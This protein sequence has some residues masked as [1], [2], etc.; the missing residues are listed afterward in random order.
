MFKKL[1]IKTKIISSTILSLISLSVILGGISVISSKDAL[2]QKSYSVLT[3]VRDS[4]VKQIN[5]FF[6]ERIGDINVL[7]KSKNVIELSNSL[8][9]IH[10]TLNLNS[11]SKFPINNTL[12]QEETLKHE[13]FFQTYAKE[14]GYYD[15]FLI[16]KKF[17]QVI[18]TQA[19]ESDYGENLGTGSLQNSGLGEVWRKV[20]ELRRPVFVDMRPYGPSADEPAMFL[21]SPVYTNGQFNSVLV[22]QISDSAI[23]SIMKFRKGY[24][25]SQEDYLVGSDHLMRSDSFI[26]PKNHSLKASF[27]NP[28]LGSVQT[29]AVKEAFEGQSDTKIVIDYNNNPVLSAYTLVKVGQDLQWALLSEIDESEVLIVP[30]ALRNEIILYSVIVLTFFVLFM[31]IVINSSLVKPLNSFQSGL[32]SFFKYL[33]KETKDVVMLKVNSSDEIGSMSQVVNENILMTKTLLE[34]DNRF[35]SEVQEMVNEVNNGFLHKRFDNNVQSENLEKLK[36]SFNK[37]LESLNTNVGSDTNKILSVLESFSKLDFTNTIKNDRGKISMALNDVS[38]LI[39]SM[40]I[41]NKSNGLTLQNS[42]TILLKNVDTLN[43]NSNETATALEETAASLEEMT[44][45]ISENTSNVGKM[46]SYA[47]TLTT[48]ANEGQQL[49]TKTT[50]AMDEINTQVS[51]IN[52]A[53]GVI[54]QISFQTNILSLNAAVEAATAGEAGKGFAVVAQE[55]RNLASRSAEAAKEIKNLVQTANSKANE[56]KSIAD[57]MISGYDGL[58]QNIAKTLELITDVESASK[59]QLAAIEQINDAVSELDR[60]TQENVSVANTTQEIAAQTDKISTLIVSNANDKEFNGKN[61]VQAKDI[62]LEDTA[63]STM[64][65]KNELNTVKTEICIGDELN[66]SC[67]KVKVKTVNQSFYDNNDEIEGEWESF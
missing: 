44:S 19:K 64:T 53:I 20:K 14:Y 54:D 32:L 10:E 28:S 46:S 2:M 63:Y 40:L 47:N 66:P 13:N 39:T 5:T 12:I 49:A 11:D 57:S 43:H 55:V 35:L 22:F 52:D 25:Y 38:K 58:N 61:D 27:S 15:V 31:F 62:G 29:L 18:Y 17:G 30:H 37:M 36:N 16:D 9:A 51:A 7:A 56:G 26:D 21:G 65:S 6:S 1:S 50:Q 60:Q 34:D 8:L 24:G 59:E 4:K 41:E 33:N 48:S 3:A 23:N 42:S 45:N 67:T